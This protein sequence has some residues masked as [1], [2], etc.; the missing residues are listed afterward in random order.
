MIYTNDSKGIHTVLQNSYIVAIFEAHLKQDS[1]HL[2]K[3]VDETIEKIKTHH[4]CIKPVVYV[5]KDDKSKACEYYKKICHDSKDC[6]MLLI[7]VQWDKG[8]NAGMQA[9]NEM[10]NIAHLSVCL[11]DGMNKIENIYMS[12]VDPFKTINYVLYTGSAS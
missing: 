9:F 11:F 5:L 12:I 2:F 10:L 3:K 8:K 1:E 7:K 6:H 4:K